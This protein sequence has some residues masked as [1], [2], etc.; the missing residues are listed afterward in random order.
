MG[1]SGSTQARPE[2]TRAERLTE[3]LIVA[4]AAVLSLGLLAGPAVVFGTTAWHLVTDTGTTAFSRLLAPV[5]CLAL[6]ALPFVL[7]RVA[8]RSSRRKDRERLTAA[9]PAVLTLLGA[10]VVPFVALCMIFVYAD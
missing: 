8:F 6:V 1:Y 4:V 10:S 2:R 7:A 3:G 5:V 9:V